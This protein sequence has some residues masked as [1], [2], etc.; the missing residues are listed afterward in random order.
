[1]TDEQL[2][3]G[4]YDGSEEAYRNLF[5]TYFEPLTFYANKYLNDWDA[6]RDMVQEVMSHLFENRATIE[7]N[8][9]LKSFLYKAVGN[10]SLNVL[11]HEEVKSRHHSIIKSH[12]DEISEDD[13][14]ELSELEARINKLMNELP[15]ACQRIFRMSRIEEKSN[16]EIA[17][18]LNLS[19]RTVETQISKALKFF[20][21][22]LKIMIIQI[23]IKNI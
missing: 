18:E 8:E 23:I 11:R 9:S 22:T 16:Q 13:S 15:E 12:S 6:S 3:Q 21:N 4:L 17:D 5:F 14:M 7:I 19:K 1:M 2:L 20:R 10:R